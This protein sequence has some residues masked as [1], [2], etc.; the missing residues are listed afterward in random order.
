VLSLEV[1]INITKGERRGKKIYLSIKYG[2][3]RAVR[4]EVT[5]TAHANS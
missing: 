2:G 3:M 5:C 4:I 1:V